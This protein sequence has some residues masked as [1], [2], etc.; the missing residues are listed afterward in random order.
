[1]RSCCLI[2]TLT[3]L[4]LLLLSWWFPT[5]WHN[6][7]LLL[8]LLLLLR[9]SRAPLLGLCTAGRPLCCAACTGVH[10]THEPR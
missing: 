2:S 6:L 9:P 3:F 8:L 7:E 1:M 5:A 4:L 10:L